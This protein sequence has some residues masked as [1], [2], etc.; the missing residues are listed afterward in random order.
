MTS[1]SSGLRGQSAFEFMFIFGIFLAALI[2][3]TW[4]SWS[5]V[6]EVNLYQKNLEIDDLLRTVAEKVDTAWI[7]GKGFSTNVT[8]PHK[9]AGTDYTLNFSSN[10]IY[11]T[12]GEEHCMKTIITQNL[13]GNF[14]VG[15]ANT[16]TNMGTYI[17][18]S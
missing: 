4:I 3:G 8:I 14:A 5:K 11:I 18:I 13:T 10:F 7:E 1:T 17:E 2:L 15:G 6:A 9:V 12:I 16:L